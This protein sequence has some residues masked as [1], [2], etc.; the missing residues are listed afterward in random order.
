MTLQD[1][2]TLGGVIKAG[3]QLAKDPWTNDPASASYDQHW[4]SLPAASEQPTL[5][6]YEG[7]LQPEGEGP[8]QF[9]NVRETARGDFFVDIPRVAPVGGLA[10]LAKAALDRA[11][12]SE[13]LVYPRDEVRVSPNGQRL[14]LSAPGRP[15]AIVY[16][17]SFVGPTNFLPPGRQ[18]KRTLEI[19]RGH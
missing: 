2:V 4:I 1:L 9:V 10:T 15:Q 13:P 18:V 11:G 7:S 14:K 12:L 16:Q 5:K 8:K 17:P 6:V 19:L 3:R